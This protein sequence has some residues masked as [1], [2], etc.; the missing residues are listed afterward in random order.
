[1]ES[2]PRLTSDA[3]RPVAAYADRREPTRRAGRD[4]VAVVLLAGTGV[5]IRTLLRLSLVDVGFDPAGITAV[6]LSLSDARYATDEAGMRFFRRIVDEVSVAPGIRSAAIVS[7]PPLIGGAGYWQNGFSIE[8]H[9]P[10]APGAEQFA[11]L[12]WVTPKYF[13]TLRIPVARGRSFT[14]SDTTGH[15][16]V[17]LVNEAFVRR[18][19]SGLDPIGQ[20]LLISIRTPQPREI[21]GI[22]ADL[23]Q[24]AVDAPAEPQMYL[25]AYQSLIGYGT[26]LVR[27]DAST[28]ATLGVVRDAIRRVDRE[29]PIFNAR[30]MG[31]DVAASTAP[32]RVTAEL[33]SVFAFVALGLAVLGIYAVGAY[34][35]GE[36]SREFGVRMALGAT[37]RDILRIVVR[38][39]MTPAL[40]GVAVGLVAAA[41]LVRALET[42]LFETEPLDP[43]TF[44]A[45]AT[46][47]AA[48]AFAASYLP[49][50]RATRVDPSVALRAE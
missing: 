33:L 24:T 12:R 37:A 34:Q 3:G 40:G 20:R 46:V 22:V 18:Y 49:A 9:P 14:E 21:V 39:A 43:V 1:L 13:A 50:R 47:L 23:R 36:R 29:Q 11:Y 2:S 16:L 32:R 6:D 45:T 17:V 25:P 30:D 19:F 4:A 27:S 42:L 38:Q 44:L 41:F 15:P 5:M 28:D 8:G 35:V 7:D 48:T 26:L 31:A 10:R